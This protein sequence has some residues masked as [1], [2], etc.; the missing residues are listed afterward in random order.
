MSRDVRRQGVVLEASN[1]IAEKHPH[2]NLLQIGYIG[3]LFESNALQSTTAFPDREEVSAALAPPL[4]DWMAQ[5][6]LLRR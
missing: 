5:T 3:Q 2:R 6:R 4:R 1:H